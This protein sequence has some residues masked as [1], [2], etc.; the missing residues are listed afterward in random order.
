MSSYDFVSVP[1][2][3]EIL[4]RVVSLMKQLRSDKGLNDTLE[5]MIEYGLENAEQKYKHYSDDLLGLTAKTEE[6]GYLWKYDKKSLFLPNQTQIM[7]KYK[8]KNL[9]ARFENQ[10]FIYAGKTY[11]SPAQLAIA[12]SGNTSVNA[13]IALYIKRPDDLRWHLAQDLGGQ[14]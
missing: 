12:M 10:V 7:R 9:F 8:G 5:R 2:P 3:S 13:W 11:D 1:V 4:I 6:E 14:A